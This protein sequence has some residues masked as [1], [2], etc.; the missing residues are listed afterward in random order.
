MTAVPYGSAGLRPPKIATHNTKTQK[1]GSDFSL[2]MSTVYNQA[3]PPPFLTHILTGST[4]RLLREHRRLRTTENG[5]P[6]RAQTPFSSVLRCSLRPRVRPPEVCV[7]LLFVSVILDTRKALSWSF[8]S[9]AFTKRMSPWGLRFS[10]QML[11]FEDTRIISLRSAQ[12][13]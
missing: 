9:S 11:R 12:L 13:R 3:H 7:F 6:L 5:S 8:P 2:V 10:I 1:I 4:A